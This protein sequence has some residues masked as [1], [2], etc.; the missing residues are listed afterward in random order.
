MSPAKWLMCPA[1]ACDLLL[2]VAACTHDYCELP[3]FP[4][5][6]YT[7]LSA[8][9]SRVYKNKELEWHARSDPSC[10][11]LECSL[12]CWLYAQYLLPTFICLCILPASLRVCVC[13]CFYFHFDF[14]LFS[15]LVLKYVALRCFFPSAYTVDLNVFHPRV[16]IF[17]HFHFQFAFLFIFFFIL[18]LSHA[19]CS[20]CCSC[21]FAC[22]YV[23]VCVFFFLVGCPLG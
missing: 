20:L 1:Y 4:V 11:S 17:F 8:T 22:V 23:C 21:F 13:V 14:Y 16:P 3:S 6:M 12:P 9:I 5:T 15:L 7:L 19:V 2:I 18:L 10:S